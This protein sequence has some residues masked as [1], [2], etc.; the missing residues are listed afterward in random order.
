MEYYIYL[1]KSRKDRE[2][3]MQGEGETLARHQKTLLEL[4]SKMHLNITRI[5]KEVVSGETIASRPEMQ[6]LLH[7]IE[8]GDCAGVLVMEVERLARGDTKDQ[9]VV[10]E[11]FKY[12]G[13][14]IITPIKTY[15]PADEYD[16]EYFEFGLFMSRREYKTIN[17]RIQ[18]GRITSAKEGKFISSTAPYGYKK[19]KI[20]NGKGYTLEILPDQADVVRMIYEWYTKGVTNDSGICQPI[21]ATAICRKL[22]MMHIQPMINDTWS[23]ASVSDILK[24]PVYI[25]KIRW[26]YRKEVKKIKDG[27]LVKTRPDNHDDYILVD[28]LHSA[29]ISE[30][31][32]AAAQRMSAKNRKMP[33]KTNVKLQN[34]LSGI[35][36]CGICGC[37]MTRLGPTSHTPYATLKCSNRYCKNISS[38][39]YLVEQKLLIFLEDWLKNYSLDWSNCRSPFP[40]DAEIKMK[41]HAINSVDESLNA[42]QEQLN[43]TYTFLEK[44]IYTT[45]IFLERNKILTEQIS[46]AERNLQQLNREYNDTLILQ[47]S[48]KEFMPRIQSIIDTYWDIENMQ[49]RNDMLKEILEKAEYTKNK[50]NT[51]G[52]REVANFTLDIYPKIPRKPPMS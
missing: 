11:A 2:A 41:E 5:Y 29:I 16:E 33:L 39:L 27:K 10:A 52:K 13:T 28:G 26:S 31:T 49:T 17:R 12:S 21:G 3:E 24:N 4:A 25:G 22:D 46:S 38:P 48:Q 6:R 19:V 37:T 8:D 50:P 7:D 35:I 9:G 43:N 47:Q 40:T 42:L 15:D 34:P 1:R 23:K 45:E 36:R 18:R 30:E 20:K 44:G 32:F 51:R 14:K